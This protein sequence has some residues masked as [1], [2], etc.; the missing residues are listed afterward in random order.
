MDVSGTPNVLSETFY[1]FCEHSK[2]PRLNFNIKLLKSKRGRDLQATWDDRQLCS[3]EFPRIN[4]IK[5]EVMQ[6]IVTYLLLCNITWRLKTTNTL[7]WA[8]YIHRQIVSK[9]YHPSPSWFSIW[10]FYM[11]STLYNSES[12]SCFTIQTKHQPIEAS[13]F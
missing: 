10:S 11:K 1:H 8:G 7:S 5:S 6:E 13:F 12:I 2:I 4:R 9:F 3:F